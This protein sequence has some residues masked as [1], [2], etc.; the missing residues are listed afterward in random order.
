MIIRKVLNNNL[1]LVEENGQEQIAMGRG[2]RFA[3]KVG[4]TIKDSDVEKVYIL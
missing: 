2:L 3:Y 4:D 1:L